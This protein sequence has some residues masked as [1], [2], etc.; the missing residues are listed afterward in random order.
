MTQPDTWYVAFGPDKTAQTDG[1]DAGVRRST[2][3]FKSEVDARLFA[4]QIVAKGLSATAGTL[5]PHQPRK[6]VGP[7][8]IER[9]ADTGSGD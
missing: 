5:N 7:A 2:R 1:S 6:L 8:Q 9:W 4:T 3:T